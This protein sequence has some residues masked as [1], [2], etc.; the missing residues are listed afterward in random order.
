M[1]NLLVTLPIVALTTVSSENPGLRGL[2]T[3]CTPNG[4]KY[5]FSPSVIC[6]D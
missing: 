5:V 4:G 3:T 1:P 6:R 2:S